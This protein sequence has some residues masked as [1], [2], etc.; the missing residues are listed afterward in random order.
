MNRRRELKMVG[1]KEAAGQS[2]V[3]VSYNRV[4]VFSATLARDRAALGERITEWIKGYRGEIV[5][6]VVKQSSDREFHCIS[7]TLF[8][9]DPPPKRKRRGNGG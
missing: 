5:D 6:K 3:Q 7:I 4:E 8:C 9:K 1:V 2:R